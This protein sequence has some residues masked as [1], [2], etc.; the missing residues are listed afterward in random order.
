MRSTVYLARVKED[1]GT[2]GV[3]RKLTLLLNESRAFASVEPDDA[4]C[5]KIHFGEE[6]NTGYVR[7]EYAALVCRAAV[8]RGAR[9]W[10]TDTN[11]LYRGRR[12]R[13]SDH[14]ALAAEHG[15]TREAIGVPIVIPDESRPDDIV[16]VELNGSFVRTAQ[17]ARMYIEAD[18]VVGLAHFKGHMMTGFGGALKNIGMG[19]A[20]RAGKL[21]QHSG[22]SP[23]VIQKRCVGCGVCVDSCPADAIILDGKKARI[24]ASKCI[25]CASCIAACAQNAIDVQWGAGGSDIQEK[26]VE[27]ARAV[28][29]DKKR[30]CV[31]LNFIIKVTAECDCLAKDDPR[32]VP[33]IGIALSVDPVSLDTASRELVVQAAGKDVFRELHPAYD[34]KRQLEYAQ[35]IGLGNMDYELVEVCGP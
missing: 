6:G 17:I 25:G 21:A 2:K 26:M 30:A 9:C 5:A 7:P 12:M 3:C 8:A 24:E 31:F 28:L 22:I 35:K 1:E 32:I 10:L 33:D 20:A 14:L 13:S 34:G 4:V 29:R 15:F 18:A 16:S 11:T 23:V 19:C 27:F